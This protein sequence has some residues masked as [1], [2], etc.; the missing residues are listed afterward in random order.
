MRMQAKVGK[1]SKYQGEYSK[2]HLSKH[3]TAIV[4]RRLRNEVF[5]NKWILSGQQ[6]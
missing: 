5:F 4:Q 6:K 1:H 2:R 3:K